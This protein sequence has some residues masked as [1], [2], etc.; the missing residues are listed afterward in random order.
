MKKLLRKRRTYVIL[1][2]VLIVLCS[3]VYLI[4]GKSYTAKI[5]LKDFNRTSHFDTEDLRVVSD[6][7]SV[8]EIGNYYA[9]DDTIYVEIKPVSPGRAPISIYSKD[10]FLGF[11][12]FV[13]TTG[14][15]TFEDYFGDFTGGFIIPVSFII[16]LIFA[17]CGSLIKY[18]SQM[19]DCMYRYDNITTLGMIIFLGFLIL[20]QLLQLFRGRHGL[21]NLLYDLTSSAQF[22]SVYLLPIAF[23]VSVLVMISNIVL[24]VKEGF[25]IRNG[26]GTLFGAF[27][28]FCT[29]L[30]DILYMF[31]LTHDYMDIG[32]ETG[33]G[34]H[35]M[36][37]AESSISGILAYIECILI[38]TM[39]VSLHAARHVPAFD[40]DHILILG[41]RINNDGTLTKL[42]SGRAD[43]A[44]EFA[45]MQKESAGKDITFVPS[46]GKGSD[47]IISEAEAV[48]NYLM[49]KGVPEDRIITEDKSENTFENIRNSVK[50]IRE[51]D[52]G[53]ASKIAFST[54]NYHVFRAGLLAWKQGIKMEG[55]GSKTKRY[56]WINAFVREF[57]ATLYSER[58]HT[59]KMITLMLILIFLA[60]A[61]MY[62]GINIW[63]RY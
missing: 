47:E 15:V 6:N 19:A 24:M 52:G 28:C 50:L 18:R 48:K 40:K 27:I 5:S 42:L 14:H 13:H 9:I 20:Q 33:L 37:F 57:I 54:T 1:A 29:F 12:V 58:K 11:R 61:F 51:K 17:F 23:V 43:R 2:L 10:I 55:I 30:P 46:G 44:L 34:R 35:V 16:F 22:L 36:I 8:A 60:A 41:C 59:L 38:A 21:Y 39:I 63:I 25:N 45:K 62:Y 4:F 3:A 26:L 49:D 31:M 53:E 32:R 56:F 7:T